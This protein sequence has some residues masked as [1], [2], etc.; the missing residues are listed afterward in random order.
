L[1]KVGRV[2]VAAEAGLAVEMDGEVV[3]T[4]PVEGELYVEPGEHLIEAKR[5]DGATSSERFVVD[6]GELVRVRLPDVR[7]PA[8]TAPRPEAATQTREEQDTS[9]ESEKKRHNW[10]PAYVLGGLSVAAL[11]TSV[12]LR[13]AAGAKESK[14]KALHDEL[15]PGDCDGSQSVGQCAELESMTKSQR[16][17]GIASDATLIASGV[18]AGATL[19]WIVY[20]LARPKRAELSAMKATPLLDVSAQSAWIGLRGQF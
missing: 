8:D 20:E 4:A 9:P 7:L 11:G 5:A 2:R 19:G 10:V 6:E 1:K 18:F 14:G 3:G 13:V 16:S 17:L 12:G 15:M